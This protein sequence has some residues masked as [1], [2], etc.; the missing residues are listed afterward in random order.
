VLPEVLLPAILLA[1]ISVL[2]KPPV[3]LWLLRR[4]GEAH[5]RSREVGFRLGQISEFSLLIGLVALQEN[6][7]GAKAAHLVEAATLLSF[8]ASTYLIVS[9]YPTPI[10][11]SDQLRR[12]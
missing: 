10:A 3:F 6:L 7:I 8:V 12:D 9:R 1:A 4:Y 5:G 11:A 2:I